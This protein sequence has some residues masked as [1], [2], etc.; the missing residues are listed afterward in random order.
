MKPRQVVT[1]RSFLSYIART[2]G[3]A[4]A[5]AALDALGAASLA[6]GEDLPYAG[7]PVL[8]GGIGKGKRVTILGAGVA[9]MTAAYELSKA[10]FHCTIL[11]ARQRAGGRSWTVRGGDR[12][13]QLDGV[14]TAHWPKGPHLYMNVGPARISHHHRAVLGYCREFGVALEIMMNDNHAAFVHDDAV[15]GGK[16]VQL[17]QLTNDAHGYFAE[18][19]DKAAATGGL[20]RP[21]DAEDLERLRTAIATF[22]DLGSDRRFHGTARSGYRLTPAPGRPTGSIREPLAFAELLKGDFWMYKAGFPDDFDQAGTMLQ[23][24]GG[25][26]QF[27]MAFARRVGHMI[28]YGAVVQEIRKTASGAR[29]V[30]RQG[31]GAKQAIDSDYLICTLPLTVLRAIP[32]DFSP[33]YQQ[34]IGEVDYATSSKIGFY[35]TRRFWEQDDGIYGG[36]SWTSR[37]VTQ[38]LYPSQGIGKPDGVLVGSYS[39]GVLPGDD[40][41]KLPVAERIEHALA[42][43]EI[44]HPGYRQ[45]VRGGVSVAWTKVPYNLG[46]W[47]EW[48]PE[49]F[50]T[51]YKLLQQPDGVMFFAGEYLGYLSSW[52]EGAI[53]SAHHAIEQLGQRLRA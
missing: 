1:R 6:W 18:L 4:A 47:A 36:L 33:A 21:M 38:I 5:F 30:L 31:G 46:S 22:G 52:Q 35:A 50:D 9:G 12:I 14:Q 11:E 3:A 37:D 25:M 51:T 29:V 43:G 42:V 20:D 13:E 8:P 16:P 32:N 45:M 41:G 24:V 23:P 26:D 27:P 34:A 44:I 39:F 40:M 10:G 19:M 49:Q 53:L 17:K 7:P 2:S 15:F 28:R 48:R